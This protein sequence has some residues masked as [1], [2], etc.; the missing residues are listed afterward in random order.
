MTAANYLAM[1]TLMQAVASTKRTWSD[2][3]AMRGMVHRDAMSFL[4]GHVPGTARL[5]QVAAASG[6]ADQHATVQRIHDCIVTGRGSAT[7]VNN[8]RWDK[9]GNLL[10]WAA[11][12]GDPSIVASTS[13]HATG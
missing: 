7:F 3:A 13:T 8:V 12:H 5:R 2:F 1:F 4:V 6:S 10:H 9:Y 11:R